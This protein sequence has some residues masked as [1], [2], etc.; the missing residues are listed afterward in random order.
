MA[1]VVPNVELEI[2]HKHLQLA[3]TSKETSAG[4]EARFSVRS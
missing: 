2:V 3:S 4:G 1:L